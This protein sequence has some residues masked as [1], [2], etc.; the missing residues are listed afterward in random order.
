MELM[1]LLGTSSMPHNEVLQS[2]VGDKDLPGI[3]KWILIINSGEV[4]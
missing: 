1:K 2:I 3:E 4:V